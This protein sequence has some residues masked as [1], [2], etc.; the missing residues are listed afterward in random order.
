MSAVEV[1]RQGRA[2]YVLGLIQGAERELPPG[3]VRWTSDQSA[4][5]GVRFAAVPA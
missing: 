1:V 4:Q 2:I 3:L 5:I